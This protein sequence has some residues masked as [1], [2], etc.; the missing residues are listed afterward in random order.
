MFKRVVLFLIVNVL[1]VA[2]DNYDVEV[3]SKKL[4]GTGVSMFFDVSY[5]IFIVAHCSK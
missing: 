1:V 3:T 5:T 4:S 2:T